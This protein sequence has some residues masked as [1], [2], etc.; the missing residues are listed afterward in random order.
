M[1]RKLKKSGFL[2]QAALAR[3]LGVSAPAVSQAVSSGRLVA[4]DHHGRRVPVGYSGRKWLK[5]AEAVQDWDNN[6]LRV[7]D[8]ALLDGETMP[9]TLPESM[10]TALAEALEGIVGWT[11]EVAAAGREGGQAAVFVVLHAKSVELAGTIARLITAAA[12]PC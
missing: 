2:T 12:R 7:D 8:F 10:W 1:P 9:A 4:Y 11:D 6:R 5:A 3:K